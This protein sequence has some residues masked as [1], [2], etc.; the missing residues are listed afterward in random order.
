MADNVEYTPEKLA[1]AQAIVNAELKRQAEDAAAKRAAYWAPVKALI[2]SD[3]WKEVTS[4]MTE[5]TR[6]YAAD[7]MLSIH[8]QALSEIMPRL[9]HAVA[10]AAPSETVVAPVVMIAPAPTSPSSASAQPDADE[11]AEADEG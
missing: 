5:V 7:N 2:D 1:E 3:A 4:K 9:E 10:T 11:T 6:T 8:V